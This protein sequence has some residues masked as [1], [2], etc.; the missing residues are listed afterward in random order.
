M[1]IKGLLCLLLLMSVVPLTHAAVYKDEGCVKDR[2]VLCSV[3]DAA[4]W[5]ELG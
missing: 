2:V 1:N 3:C 5:P 4:C